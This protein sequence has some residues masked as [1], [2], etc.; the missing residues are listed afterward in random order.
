MS[1]HRHKS[2]D[3]LCCHA[4]RRLVWF[5]RGCAHL[6]VRQLLESCCGACQG[7]I[8]TVHGQIS[9]VAWAPRKHSASLE[10]AEALQEVLDLQTRLPL[11]DLLASRTP[12]WQAKRTDCHL[13]EQRPFTLRGQYR[14]SLALQCIT[15]ALP[16]TWPTCTQP[17]LN[18]VE[19]QAHQTSLRLA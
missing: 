19:E 13:T 11:S 15:Q 1:I 6:D 16:R 8:S 5:G 14:T 3:G 4:M 12:S 9:S 2:C 17:T 10:L 18:R 7:S